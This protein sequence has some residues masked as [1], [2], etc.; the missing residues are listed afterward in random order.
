[1]NPNA[2][3]KLPAAI[4]IFAVLVLVAGIGAVGFFLTNSNY[5]TYA[6]LDASAVPS[7]GA[8]A[9]SSSI[10]TSASQTEISHSITVTGGISSKDFDT[11]LYV[12][13]LYELKK[14]F[15]VSKF[16][17][18]SELSPSVVVQYAFNHLYYDSLVDMPDEK[19][20][21]LRQVL[22]ESIKS[23]IK[24]LFGN[25]IID[26]FKSDLYNKN[27]QVFEMWQP[28]YRRSVYADAACEKLSTDH[29]RITATFYTTKQ[30]NTVDSVVTGVFIKQNGSFIL[31]SMS[32][33]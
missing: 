6:V 18:V 17:S 21:L 25:T 15:A 20:M 33:K 32:T 31:V 4:L 7:A 29:Y 5:K 8:V 13:R 28:N 27:K 23:E 2:K 10:S 19:A 22:P 3:Q 1:M 14:L 9:A 11:E 12:K 26:I 24:T 16:N 30:K